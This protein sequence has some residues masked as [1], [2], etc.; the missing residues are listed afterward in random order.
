M[1]HAIWSRKWNLAFAMMV[2]VI[3]SA[4]RPDSTIGPYGMEFV[5][6]EPGSFMMG[7]TPGEEDC[8]S[9]WGCE[10][11][12]DVRCSASPTPSHKVRITRGFQIGRYEVT[13]LQWRSVMGLN[14]SY[15]TGPNRPVEQ[16]SGDDINVFMQRLNGQNDGYRYRLPTEAEWEYAAR[17]G[18]TGARYGP[19]DLIAWYR[20]NSSGETQPVGL[21]APNP[22][23]LYDMIGNVW[24]MTQDWGYRPYAS[25]S[26][27]NP[28]GP[29]SGIDQG[30]GPVKVARGGAF[31]DYNAWE[32]TA[33]K[34][35]GLPPT[36]WVVH[37][38][39]CVRE[40]LPWYMRLFE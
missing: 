10:V 2:A 30:L 35:G 13:Q 11:S 22:W 28:T 24:E 37:G 4:C 25:A 23:G 16:V 33:W 6:I 32:L 17:A 12:N 3:C 15:F 39:R 26:V 20:G 31:N 40:R 7:C 36:G 29:P 9:R 5:Q 18:T 34:R 8:D 21:K 27:T 38:F 14:P 19:L 1:I